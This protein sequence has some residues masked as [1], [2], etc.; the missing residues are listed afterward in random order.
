MFYPPS[1]SRARLLNTQCSRLFE[2]VV[3]ASVE[4]THFD[5]CL[6][7]LKQLLLHCSIRRFHGLCYELFKLLHRSDSWR[8]HEHWHSK[9]WWWWHLRGSVLRWSSL[10]SD[11]FSSW[12]LNLVYLIVCLHRAC[13]AGMLHCLW[14]VGICTIFWSVHLIF[15]SICRAWNCFIVFWKISNCAV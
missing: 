2:R 1:G 13:F 10:A 14:Y 11:W 4:G 6:F 12:I 5:F 3:H 9:L 7:I 8:F 15:H